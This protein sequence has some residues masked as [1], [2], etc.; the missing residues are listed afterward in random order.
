MNIRTARLAA[1]I[2]MVLPLAG[3]LVGPDYHRP[4]PA[5]PPATQYKELAAQRYTQIAR[6]NPDL[7][8]DLPGWL[9]RLNS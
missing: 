6:D 8:G 3:C 1:T 2:S 4:P 5:S 9:A 7:A